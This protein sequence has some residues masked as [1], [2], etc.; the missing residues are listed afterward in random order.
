MVRP[1]QIV[2]F[3]S[4]RGEITFLMFAQ[5]ESQVERRVLWINFPG[6]ILRTVLQGDK[7]SDFIKET[8]LITEGMVNR[9]AV[10]VDSRKI[11]RSK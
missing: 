6:T 2:E 1:N 5:N 7:I 4:E 9:Y 11:T 10:T 3:D 8:K